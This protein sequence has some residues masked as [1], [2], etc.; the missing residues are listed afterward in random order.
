MSQATPLSSRQRVM[1]AL[2]HVQPDRTPADLLAVPEIWDAL[3]GV[4]R[5]DPSPFAALSRWI[6]PRRE[7]ILNVLKIDCR[8]LS[9][10]MFVR[11]PQTML[12][13]GAQVDWWG[14]ANR[15]TPNRM[16]R[17]VCPD[18]LVKDVWGVAAVRQ[19]NTFGVYED[20]AQFPLAGAESIDDLRHFRW[21]QPDWWDFADV[22]AILDGL[23]RACGDVHIRY[24][25][26]SIF[27]IAWQL[28]G[29]EKFLTDLMTCPELPCY[30]MDRLLEVHMENTRR[31]LEQAAGQVDMIYVYD[32]VATSQ[33][34][35]ISPEIWRRHIRPRHERIIAVGKRFGTKFMYHTDGAVGPLIPEFIDM[36]VDLLNPVQTDA[37]G[38]DP[39]WL[40]E[41]FGDRLSF[42]GGVSIVRTLPKGTPQSIRAEV[43]RLVNLLGKGGGYILASSHHIQA[44]TPVQNILAM[45]EVELRQDS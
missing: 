15:S 27:E 44:D 17:Q 30:I 13:P 45:Y 31:F 37:S 1:A 35:L 3:F 19:Q 40:K 16:W 14:S 7:A 5:P 10:D 26:G 20:Y 18:G 34:L 25:V 9:H 36:G 32:D 43:R 21:P 12:S 2:G 29:L 42:H 24:R 28:C 11:Y 23:R 39:R 41:T 22:P 6:E 38:M 8:V 4:L 33:S